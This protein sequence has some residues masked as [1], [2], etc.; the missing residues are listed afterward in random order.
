MQ[1]YFIKF[2]LVFVVRGGERLQ[3]GGEK[4]ERRQ[5][6]NDRLMML[7]MATLRVRVRVY[8]CVSVCVQ[9]MQGPHEIQISFSYFKVSQVSEC[10]VN[11]LGAVSHKF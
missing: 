6:K 1:D 4:R 3:Q 2:E 11:V 8:M 10:H 7:V 9:T 5:D